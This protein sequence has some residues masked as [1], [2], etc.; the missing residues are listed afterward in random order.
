[1]NQSITILDLYNGKISIVVPSWCRWMA[2]DASGSLW[3]YQH[4]PVQIKTFK[5]WQEPQSQAISKSKHAGT[6]KPPEDYTQ[7]LY[8]WS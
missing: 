1:M 8:T 7:E 5:A 2:V 4:K 6:I 3:F